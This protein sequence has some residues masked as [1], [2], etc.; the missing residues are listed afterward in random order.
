MQHTL[1]IVLLCLVNSSG[2][3]DDPPKAPSV[4]EPALREDLLKRTKSDQAARFALIDWMKNNNEVNKGKL[5][6][7]KQEEYT[8][9]IVAVTQADTENT[10]WFKTIIE[11][12]GWPTFT[13]VG[14]D[15]G[16]SAWLLVQHADADPKFQR[17]CL[18]LMTKQPKTEVSLS[19]LAYLTDRVLLAEGKKQLYGTQFIRVEGKSQPRPIEDE[20]NVDKRRA[21]M[22]LSTLAEY[23]KIIEQQYGSS[24]SK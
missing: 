24:K 14:K 12:H 3:A 2:F 5:S 20:Q 9:L 16:Q 22:G 19:N 4:K 7:E 1:S 10:K 15:G 6:K 8:K 23:A 13:M 21:E 11:K 17:L 18:D